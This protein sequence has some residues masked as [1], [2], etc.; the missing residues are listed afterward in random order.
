[1][2]VCVQ[3]CSARRVQKRVVGALELELQV[4]VS[5]LMWGLG[6]RFESVKKITDLNV[7]PS[8]Q[9]LVQGLH[10]RLD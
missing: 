6:A 4:M 7:S 8:L 5:S 1:M 9:S 3:D 10:H 2:W